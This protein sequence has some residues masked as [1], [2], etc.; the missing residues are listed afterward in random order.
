M[1]DSDKF[2]LALFFAENMKDM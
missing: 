1:H 2:F